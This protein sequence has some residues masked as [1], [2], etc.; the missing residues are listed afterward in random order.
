MLLLCRD[1][2]HGSRSFHIKN[3]NCKTSKRVYK[4]KLVV[5][6]F[7]FFFFFLA[8]TS[9][10]NKSWTNIWTLQKP[11]QTL[12]KK[13]GCILIYISMN[14]PGNNL[15][16][17]KNYILFDFNLFENVSFFFNSLIKYSVSQRGIKMSSIRT[18]LLILHQHV[19]KF[20]IP[21]VDGTFQF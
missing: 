12:E 21:S 17:L 4:C 8:H 19:C 18:K 15:P 5:C 16:F 10:S 14:C 2:C 1:C 7:S 11:T 9:F 3:A 13:L 6:F 20:R